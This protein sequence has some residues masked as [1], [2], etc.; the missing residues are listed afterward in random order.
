MGA[1][2]ASLALLSALTAV[3]GC[4]RDGL[5]KPPNDLPV[6]TARI[7]MVNGMPADAFTMEGE[8]AVPFAGTPVQVTLDGSQSVDDDGAITQYRWF[9]GTM[10]MTRGRLVP[11]GEQPTWPADEMSP[12]VTLGEG[13]WSFTLWVVDNDG[14]ISEPATVSITVGEP[15][16]PVMPDAGGGG[17]EECV[18][19]VVPD[20]P[21]ACRMCICDID[22]MCRMNVVQSACDA[23]CWAL[24]S[25]VGTNC[26]D[27]ATMAMMGDYSCLTGNCMAQLTAAMSGPTPM[28]ATPAG[29]CARMCPDE[30]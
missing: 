8:I 24:I 22:D 27:F 10:A 13:A 6:A 23:A 5:V 21:E 30:C 9:S 18:A 2:L 11:E 29:A 16:E 3:A 26:P 12:T 4:R 1:K 19:A 15:M 17:V 25:C 7:T 28:G 20:V 14:A